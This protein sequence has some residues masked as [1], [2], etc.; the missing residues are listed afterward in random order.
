MLES[1]ITSKT[2][3]RLLLKFFLNSNTTAYLRNLASEFGESTNAIR[4]ELNRFEESGLLTSKMSGNKKIFRANTG[5]PFFPEINKLLYKHSGIDQII[6]Q[7]LKKIGNLHKA[8][9]TGDLAE[10]KAGNIIDVILVGSEMNYEYIARLVNKAEE[11]T[12][13]KVRYI[14]IRPG[15]EKKYINNEEALLIWSAEK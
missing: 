10:G 12:S 1:L 14:T 3:I 13:L 15:E 11:S 9:L 7:V 8:F 2:R 5:H 4:Q 6:D